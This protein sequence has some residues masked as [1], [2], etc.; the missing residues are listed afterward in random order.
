MDARDRLIVALDVESLAEAERLLDR[1]QGLATRFKIGSQL[2]TAAGPPA[3][4]LVQKR[5]AG[6]FL[7]LKF[8]DTRTTVAGAAREAPRMGVLMF[9]VH[10][11]GGRAMMKAAAESAATTAR[12][13]G[14]RRA[15]V[16]AGT[17]VTRP[18]RG[19]GAQRRAVGGGLRGRARPPPDPHGG[20]IG[21]GRLRRLAQRDR[22]AAHQP[23]RGLGDRDSGGPARGQRLRRSVAHRDAARGG[24]G[25]GSL[26]GGRPAHH[27]GVRSGARRRGGAGGDGLVIAV[28]HAALIRSLYEI[29]AIRFGEF[30]L[31]SGI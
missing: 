12:E 16:L 14:G 5:G 7:D 15:V 1:L 8:H 19:G 23:G 13:T 29:G 25:G 24:A 21:T 22:G 17:G 31:K 10:A 27:R 3:G 18:G 30:T 28:A 2:F 6:V 26:P 4:E 9:N 11:S 20:G